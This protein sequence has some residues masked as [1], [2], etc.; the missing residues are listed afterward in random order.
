MITIKSM[1]T[2]MF[3]FVSILYSAKG[4]TFYYLYVEA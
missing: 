4:H 2:S 3:I 1:K